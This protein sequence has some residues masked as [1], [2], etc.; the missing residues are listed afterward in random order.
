MPQKKVS[1]HTAPNK[2]GRERNVTKKDPSPRQVRVS[3]KAAR[4]GSAHPARMINIRTIKEK[5]ISDVVLSH[6][7]TAPLLV[8]VVYIFL[9][10]TRS[11]DL[12]GLSDATERYLSLS[13][14]QL[15]AFMLP[16]VFYIRYRSLD[17][18]QTLRVRLFSPDKIMFTVLCALTLIVMSMLL[19]ALGLGGVYFSVGETPTGSGGAYTAY[20][21]VCFAL[22]PAICEEL[23]FRSVILSEYQNSSVPSAVLISTLFFSMIH[24]DLALLP[25]YVLSG[26]VLCMCLYATGSVFASMLVHF[27]YNLFVLFGAQ[28]VRAA[29]GALADA[30]LV[31]ILLAVL[32]LVLC[33]L[34]FGECERMYQ[35]YAK[36]GADSSYV[37]KYKHGGGT[38]AFFTALLSPMSLVCIVIFAVAA[39]ILNQK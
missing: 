26:L 30:T 10:I 22:I 4:E 14:M 16:T 27:S 33:I 20:Y 3:D 6:T 25:F 36:R 23:L 32:L 35:A 31:V 8:A 17:M 12:S 18:K 19:S 11:I 7:F 28:T 2:Q 13:S 34:T 9:L 15:V 24:F 29:T 5:R 39:L 21:V 1:A 38:V 37:K